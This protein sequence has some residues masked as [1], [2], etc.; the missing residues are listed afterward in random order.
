MEIVEFYYDD[1][2]QILEVMFTTNSDEDYR[3][4][5]LSLET[6]KFYSPLII[7]EEDIIDSDQELIA[8]ILEEYFKENDLPE[9][10]LH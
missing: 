10:D 6:L 1:G 7:D 3:S 8:E 2:E 4:I 5:T 9:V